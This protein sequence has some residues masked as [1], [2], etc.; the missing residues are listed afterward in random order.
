MGLFVFFEWVEQHLALAISA[1]PRLVGDWQIKRNAETLRTPGALSLVQGFMR[2]LLGL[3]LFSGLLLLFKHLT[4]FS[5]F[6][7][8]GGGLALIDL[9]IGKSMADWDVHWGSGIF[10]A[11]FAS[12]AFGFFGKPRSGFPQ[13]R[14]GPGARGARAAEGGASI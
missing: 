10:V 7:F 5:F 12:S 4:M 13:K 11:G 8:L 14:S 3:S 1:A 2:L 9:T 6:I